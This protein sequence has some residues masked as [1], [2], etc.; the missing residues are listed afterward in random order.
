MS[1]FLLGVQDQDGYGTYMLFE[2]RS[3]LDAIRQF[4]TT[5]GYSWTLL[6]IWKVP[7]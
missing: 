2:A 7:S 6:S 1:E 4:R 5:F 3:D